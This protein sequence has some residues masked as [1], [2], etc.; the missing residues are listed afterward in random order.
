MTGLDEG[1]ILK[2]NT[3][4]TGDLYERKAAAYLEQQ[5]LAILERNY[6]CRQGEIDL[7][8]RDTGYLVFVEVKYRRGE[9]AGN[10]LEAVN[11]AKQKAIGA[12][13]RYYLAVRWHSSDIPCRFDVIGI[14]G[15]QISWIK[16]AFEWQI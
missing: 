6:R 7:I 12:V 15:E 16:N 13:A 3:R 4:K 14:D 1:W 11:K 10:S 2:Q 8:A 9:R 5:G